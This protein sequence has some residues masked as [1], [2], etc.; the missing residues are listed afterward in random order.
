MTLEPVLPSLDD[1]EN[2]ELRDF[3][4]RFWWS[5][6]LTV[7]VFVLAMFGHRLQWMDM[8]IQSWVEFALSTP[9]VLWAGWP[10]F[11]R[12]WQSVIHRSPNMWTLIG[13]GTGAAFVY[14][15]VAT[16]APQV[17]PASFMAMGRVAVYFEAAAVIISLTLLGQVMELKARSQT[18]AAI[19]SLLGLAPKTARR[20]RPDG[21]EENVA[22][23]Q[24]HV[25]DL[26]RV[27]P[28][29]KVPVDG[30]VTE[31]RS[32]IDESM[33]TGEP[34]PVSKRVGDKVI[35][36]TINSSGALVMRSEKV[37]SA[38]VLAQIVQMV[39]QAQRSKAPMQ[40]MA[41][42]VA[43]YFVVTVVA[44]ALLT[45]LGWGFFGPNPSWVYGLINAVAVLIIA[46]PCALGLAT[47]M[48]IWSPPVEATRVLFRDAQPLRIC[49]RSTLDH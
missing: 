35:G 11:T 14:S 20:I 12:G 7:M 33:L 30:V 36:A 8:R 13:L 46:C 22:L 9:I 32:A 44:I 3:Q 27:R 31:G 42:V 28:G 17:F 1:D 41:D 10:F 37:G 45:F 47:P 43:G 23:T 6:P 29:E 48:S 49:A 16:I 34:L 21:V 39:A 18:S 2:S 40:R 15:V 26:L 19:K 38:T 4:R 25:G 24:V 5:L